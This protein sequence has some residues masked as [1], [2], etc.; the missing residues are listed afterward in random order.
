MPR[1]HAKLRGKLIERGIDERYL[2]GKLKLSYQSV[3]NR[4]IYRYPWTAWEMYQVL[5]IINEPPEKLHEYFPPKPKG[6][7]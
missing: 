7:V 6:A 2:A 1:T 3:S 5:A 4:F